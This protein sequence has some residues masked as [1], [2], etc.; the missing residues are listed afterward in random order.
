[1]K[2]RFF[3]CSV[4]QPGKGYDSD[5]LKRIIIN[6][7]FILYENTSQKGVYNE[8]KPNDILLLKYQNKLI[9][10]GLASGNHQKPLSGWNLYS[11][12]EDWFFHDNLNTEIGVGFKGLQGYTIGGGQYGTVK[13]VYSSFGL[14][15]MEEIDPTS[16]LLKN[17][18]IEI[19]KSHKI[20]VMENVI[21]LLKYK[22]EIILQ[23]PP[24]TGKTRL[25]KELAK[26]L[27]VSVDKGSPLHI[28]NEFFKNFNPEDSKVKATREEFESKLKDFYEKFPKVD[29]H[30]MTLEDYC[31]GTGANDSFC[32]WIERG[33]QRLGYYFPGSSRSYLIY[34]S[35]THDQYSSHFKHSPHLS[36]A[37]SIEEA[38]SRLAEMIAHLV[39]REDTS[40]VDQNLGVSYII[41]ILNSYYPE[42]YFPINGKVALNNLCKLL[43]IDRKGLSP[44][45]MNLKVQEFFNQKKVEYKVDMKNYDFMLFLF[46]EF[47]L[48]GEIEVQE[49]TII[50]KGETK[51]IQFHPA[52]TYE[53]FV[54]GIVV[55]TNDDNKPEYMVVNKVLG[56]FA[57]KA[58]KNHTA[59][60]VLIIDEINRANLPSVLGEL[61]YALEYRYDKDDVEG[62]TV[63]SM[64][65]LKSSDSEEELEGN[66]LIL[67]KNLFI[68]G[69]MNTAD[70]SVGHID[71]AIRRRFSFVD[72]LPRK[73]PVHVDAKENFEMVSSLFVK[74]PQEVFESEANPERSE[75]LSPDFRPEDVW[76][77]HSYFLTDKKDEEAKQEL[78]IKMKYEVVPL[79][80]E[81]IKDGIL[82]N[83]EKVKEVI[84]K[85]TL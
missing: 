15:K 18:K 46:D 36:E 44:L 51:L 60:F 13:E 21:S 11:P 9:A 83:E 14:A 84:N 48:K 82:I 37:N 73:E 77:G 56:E 20:K 27:T 43:K 65:T 31:I 45:Q 63:E 54:R 12:L 41:K 47:D 8:I 66:K 35:K 23:G 64:Y 81:Y 17:I 1:M 19:M 2:K 29:L 30:K 5:N 62:T 50:S 39:K 24:G 40:K 71:S 78:K 69:T 25:A 85:I 68:I 53:D 72:V 57:E 52:Y 32:W 49:N 42:K 28:I 34:Y 10:Y 7:A 33:L 6:K 26:G 61:I 22:K 75:Y 4:G 79:L 70:R 74:N 59:N 80:N 38:M 3:V 76:I 55:E 58:L 16:K 67:P